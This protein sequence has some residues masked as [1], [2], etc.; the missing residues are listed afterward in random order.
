MG[1][2][3][4]GWSWASRSPSKLELNKHAPHDY[5]EPAQSESARPHSLLKLITW[6]VV[7]SVNIYCTMK[8]A[9]YDTAKEQNK[10]PCWKLNNDDGKVLLLSIMSFLSYL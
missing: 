9:L 6:C 2:H 3:K 4:T 5:N 10:P 1:E 7:M 8:T